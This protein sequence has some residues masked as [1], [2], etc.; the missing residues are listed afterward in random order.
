MIIIRAD[1]AMEDRQRRR[2]RS[3]E[4][5]RKTSLRSGAFHDIIVLHEHKTVLP[6]NK[7]T[8]ATR[9]IYSFITSSK[10]MRVLEKNGAERRSSNH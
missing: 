8:Q 9:Q 6:M 7:S 4:K 2:Q 3:M 1:Q 10:I 5:W